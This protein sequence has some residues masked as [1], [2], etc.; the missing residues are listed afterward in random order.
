MIK[1]ISVENILDGDK[2]LMPYYQLKDGPTY[3]RS[4][5]G[6]KIIAPAMMYYQMNS[7]YFNTQ[8]VP[9]IGQATVTDVTLDCGNGQTLKI[10]TADFKFQ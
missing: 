7:N 2:I 3:T 10:N 1:N 4:L 8:I 9:Q 6:L 5:S